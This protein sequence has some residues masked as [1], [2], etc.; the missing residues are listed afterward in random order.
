MDDTVAVSGWVDTK[1]LDALDELRKTRPHSPSVQMVGV[2][3]LAVGLDALRE[4]HALHL[5]YRATEDTPRTSITLRLPRHLHEEVL[6][7]AQT[8]P[9][10]RTVSSA[11]HLALWVGVDRLLQK[12]QADTAAV[13]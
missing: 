12:M 2:Y 8:I 11:M 3:A 1:L 9:D 7:L 13:V 4:G 6:G 5:K 10:A